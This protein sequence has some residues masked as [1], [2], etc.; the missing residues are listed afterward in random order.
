MTTQNTDYS[1]T[2]FLPNTSFSMRGDLTK[3]EPGI[4]DA[5]NKMDLYGKMLEKRRGAKPFILHDGPPYA[6]G[7]IHIGH[8]FNKIIK[9]IIIK[10]RVM[11]GYYS[12]YVP[13]WDCHGLPIEQALLK[14]MKMGKRHIEDIPAFRRS[15]RDFANRFLDI[16]REEFK[17]LGVQGAWDKPY[18]TMTNAY[19]GAVIGAFRELLEKGHIHR[20]KK[21][22]YWCVSCETALADAE[23][24]YAD[25]TS[26][27]IYVRFPL[28]TL[29]DG[30]DAVAKNRASIVIWTTTPW[31]LPS[32][33]AA[34]VAK[35]ED[36]R[37][38]ETGGQYLLVA[39][40]LADAFLAATGLEA[41]K[42]AVIPGEKLV[43]L[44]YTHCL[45]SHLPE[46]RRFARP[47]I[48]TDFVDM[49]TGTGIV[50]IAPG[51]GEED[52][53]AGKKWGLEI[54]CPVKED[55]KFNADAGIFEGMKVFEA[56]PKVVETL[57]ADGLLLAQ[58]K[59]EHSYPHCWR[60]KQ[61]VIFRATEQWFLKVDLDGLR[62]KLQKAAD[63]VSWLPE[64]SHGRMAAMLKTR[65]DWCLSRQRYWGTPIIAVYCKDCGKVQ[66]DSAFL[67]RMEERVKAEGS[68]FW[69]SEPV[70]QLLGPGPHKCSC[71]GERFAKEK[72]IMDVWLDSGVSW[73][74]VLKGGMLGPGDF[75]PADLY[76]EGSDQHRGWFQTSLIPSVALNGHP[77]YKAVLT[78]G[79]VLDEHGRAMHKSMGNVLP[80]QEIITKY[81]AEILRLWAALCDYADDIR[82]SEKILSGPIDMY[83]KIRNTVRYLLGNLSDFNPAKHR[84]ADD[85]LVETDRYI[86][87]R[88][89]VTVASVEKHYEA[90]QFRQ[91]IR[92]VA[93]FCILDLSAFYLDS[94]KDRLYTFSPDSVE[95][96]SAQTVLYDILVSVLKMSAPVLSFTAEEAWLTARAEIDPS[97]ED[98]VFLSDYPK[99]PAA[100]AD[101]ALLERWEKVMLVRETVT[102]AI[103]EVRKTGAV[104]SSLEARI[105]LRTCDPGMKLFLESALPLWPQVAIVSEAA[106]E[107]DAAAPELEVRVSKAEGAKCPRCWQWRRDLGA[108]PRHAEVCGRCA[109]ALE[110]AVK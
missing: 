66:T 95:R 84:V 14:E 9:D 47:V 90:F 91:A 86:R 92:A 76:L 25:K 51:H 83:R 27:S 33:M 38:L 13:G 85:K 7:H 60:C 58:K 88:L 46:A 45:A 110:A 2:V 70:E 77:P 42:G 31:T 67:K 102:K 59:I 97:L 72:D 54:F 22:I 39:D 37:V 10:S 17:R 101:Q 103:E 108:D 43:G 99:F 30:L 89:A 26:P 16:Q 87:A 52:F 21:T 65:P 20:D 75:Y 69:F 8:A 11:A 94:L 41:V 1:K 68:D 40:K 36:Y 35:T 100:W 62:E 44:K 53:H 24:E 12:P 98:S 93:D 106:V 48:A 74:A 64:A 4:L 6:N 49:S 73:Y 19:E 18:V 81:G 109:G 55:G 78:H 82:I 80:P 50:H 15:A 104:G 61:P 34:A 71:G 28:E 96:R 56:N 79:M 32:N 23:V 5:W 107:F 3:K 63:G 29:P 57:Q 105:V